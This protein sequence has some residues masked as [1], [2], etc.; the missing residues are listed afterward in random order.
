MK[1]A[2]TGATGFIG[3][4]LV[5]YLTAQGHEVIR[6][7]RRSI[8]GP[9]DRFYDVRSTDSIPDLTGMD[10]LIHTAFVKYDPISMPD[11]SAVNITATLALEKACHKAGAKFIFLSTMSAHADAVSRY[12]RHKYDL[13]QKLDASRDLIFKLGLVIGS[14]GLFDSIRTAISKGA[15]IPLVGSGAQPIQTIAVTDVCRI[16]EQAII[17]NMTG[18]YTIG[19]EKVYTLRDLY[20]ATALRLNKKPV[21]ISVPYFLVNFALSAI[22]LLRIPF[23]VSKENLLGLRQL[24]AFDTKNDLDRLGVTILDMDQALDQQMKNP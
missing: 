2:V 20:A 5:G 21:F 22:E 10:A 3:A 13:E 8:S 24:K 14:R 16:I 7:Q 4:E 12:G 23:N 6:L 18:S 15:F 11:S 17:H 9:T 1:I 19:T